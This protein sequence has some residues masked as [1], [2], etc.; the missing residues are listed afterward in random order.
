MKRQSMLKWLVCVGMVLVSIGPVG[1]QNNKEG[2]PGIPTPSADQ[3][4][5]M[6]AYMKA[7]TP[8]ENHERLSAMVGHW[9]A[10]VKRWNPGMPQVMESKGTCSNEW[11]LNDHFLLTKYK[12][13]FMGM[14]FEGAGITGYDNISKRYFSIWLD[15]MSTGPKTEYG[16]YDESSK[17]YNYT[18]TFESPLGKTI[19]SKSTTTVVGKDEHV[20]TMYQG[21]K[22]LEKVMEITYKRQAQ[23]AKADTK[24]SDAAAK[25]SG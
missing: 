14:P 6:M 3:M 11:I 19:K 22:E 2:E 18:G 9:D 5:E 25:T 1:A 12:G 24:T 13:D 15:N 10:L 7:G 21:E 8:N 17:T 16:Q 23:S 4:E 20:F